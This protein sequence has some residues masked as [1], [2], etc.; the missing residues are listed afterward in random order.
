MTCLKLSDQTEIRPS[1]GVL[2]REK[3]SSMNILIVSAHPDPASLTNALSGVSAEQLREEGH[4]VR[5]SDLYAA[6]LECRG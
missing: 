3:L 1:F 5:V 4:D 2:S 6:G